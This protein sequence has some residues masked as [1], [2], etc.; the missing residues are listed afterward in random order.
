MKNR[1]LLEEVN[2]LL[3]KVSDYRVEAESISPT[4]ITLRLYWGERY[5][6]ARTIELKP[7]Q[8]WERVGP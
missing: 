6:V 7:G 4:L 2:T 3:A 1:Q 8:A 5:R